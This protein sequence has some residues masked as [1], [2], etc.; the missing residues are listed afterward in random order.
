MNFAIK[1][2][3]WHNQGD[4]KMKKDI[5]KILEEIDGFLENTE[6]KLATY[7]EEE[8]EDA[9][10]WQIL[11]SNPTDVHLESEFVKKLRAL[12]KRAKERGYE[13][14]FIEECR[15]TQVLF[16]QANCMAPELDKFFNEL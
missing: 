6:R 13:K 11:Q 2:N 9:E 12:R 8:K 7:E 1:H 14:R 5:N 3:P 10:F 4:K 16:K 15:K